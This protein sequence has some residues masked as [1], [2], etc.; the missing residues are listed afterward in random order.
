MPFNKDIVILRDLAKRYV[1]IC[2]L[3]VQNERRNLWRRHN[4]LQRT[5]PPIYVRWFSAW[6]EMPESALRCE[7]PFYQGHEDALRQLLFQ[8][9]IGD[10]FVMEPWITQEATYVTP[11]EGLWGPR[12]NHT[13]SPDPRGAWKFNPPIKNLEDVA[14]LVRP[15]HLID[16]EATARNVARL[17]EAVGD[18]IEVNVDR[19]PIYR[20]WHGDISADLAHLRGL[21]PM[22]WDMVDNPK[23]LHE[24]LAFMRD[25]ILSTHAQAEAAG[26]WHLCDHQN[27][28]MPY[29]LELPDPRANG[30]HT[31]R[32]FLWTF[33]ASQETTAV[34]PRMFEEF[35]LRYQMLLMAPFGLVAYGCCEDLTQ[36]IDLLRQIP[37]LRRIA[38]TPRADLRRCAEQIGQD[39]VL[40]WRPN[41][42]EMVCCGFDAE[43]IRRT[44]REAL[45]ICK[46][47]Y[48]DVTLKDVHTVQNQPQRLAEWVKI[49]REVADQYV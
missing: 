47:S 2:Q 29:A 25:G 41:P 43:Y 9:T 17:Q 34:G 19:A 4:S 21:E 12:I 49:V 37:N 26:D 46:D 28:A 22:M 31:R 48:V 36:K 3:D 14:K 40:S 44:M 45:A 35:M 10:D 1:E 7:D 18:I 15:R 23:W 8:D 5:R 13:P 39:Y 11:P 27:Q 32:A 20:M 6:P 42:A 30:P 16:E 24:L 33:V 38:V